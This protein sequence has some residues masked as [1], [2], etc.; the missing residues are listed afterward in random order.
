MVESGGGECCL[1]G[2]EDRRWRGRDIV[3]PNGTVMVQSG[4]RVR[5]QRGLAGRGEDIG[6]RSFD[7]GFRCWGPGVLE[8]FEAALRGQFPRI[9]SGCKDCLLI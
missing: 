1:C 5:W 3:G 4:G 7:L 6:A 9:C 2:H 8:N